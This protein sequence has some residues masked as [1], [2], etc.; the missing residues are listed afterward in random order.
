MLNTIKRALGMSV[1]DEVVG[2]ICAFAGSFAPEGFLD[3]NGRILPI[4]N[5]AYTSL[6]SIIGT[7]YGGDGMNTFALPD[8]RPVDKN[9][10]PI[11]WTQAGVPRQVICYAGVY[12][13]RP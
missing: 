8:L 6:F 9:G 11:D 1:N 5:K 4:N 10:N 3:C 12:P 2:S 7:I 13:R